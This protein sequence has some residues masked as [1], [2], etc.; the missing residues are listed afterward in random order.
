M[1]KDNDSSSGPRERI[2]GLRDSK[3][4][5]ESEGKFQKLHDYNGINEKLKKKPQNL[6]EP[7]PTFG[8]VEV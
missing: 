5:D 7:R 8:A 6:N 4:E 3:S 2:I 1:G